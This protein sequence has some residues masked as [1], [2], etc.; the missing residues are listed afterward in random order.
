MVNDTLKQVY[1]ALDTLTE[2]ELFTV[3]KY[4]WNRVSTLRTMGALEAKHL[5]REEDKIKFY[6][7]KIRADV[8]GKILK[9]KHTTASVLV[10]NIIL[11]VP[12]DML[13]KA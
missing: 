8:E 6:N 13:K 9:I 12:L 10:G 11:T 1:G 4:L 3:S 7:R 5:F 2:D